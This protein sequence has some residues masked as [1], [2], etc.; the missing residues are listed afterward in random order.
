MPNGHVNVHGHTH[1]SRREGRH[2]NVSVEQLD[3]RP[4]GLD[5]LR[6]LARRLVAGEEP[7]GATTLEQ[8][9]GLEERRA[10]GGGR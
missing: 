5:R 3:Y 4:I 9:R 1:A 6:L 8:V 10:P 7:A 2:V